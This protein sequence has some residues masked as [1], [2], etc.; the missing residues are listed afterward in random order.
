M[1]IYHRGSWRSVCT[2]QWT[3]K[4]ARVACRMMGYQSAL[5]ASTITV[6]VDNK[7]SVK[8]L[9][10]NGSEKSLLVCKNSGW[11]FQ[12]Y[13]D[14]QKCATAIC[15][16]KCIPTSTCTFLFI[17]QFC[18]FSLFFYQMKLDLSPHLIN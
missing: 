8:D 2:K 15:S 13:R 4:D 16:G 10:C 1:E 3:L 12:D 6:N 18:E 14:D 11:K 9:R 5:H 17:E 7:V